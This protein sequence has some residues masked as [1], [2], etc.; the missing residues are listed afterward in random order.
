MESVL[1]LLLHFAGSIALLC[2]EKGVQSSGPI[3]TAIVQVSVAVY[4][5]I[6]FPQGN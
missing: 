1:L 6:S 2:L 4:N 3:V 5:Y